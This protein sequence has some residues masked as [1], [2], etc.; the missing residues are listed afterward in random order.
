M[1]GSDL[2]ENLRARW[3]GESDFPETA[4]RPLTDWFNQKILKKVYAEHDRK[5]IETQL[6][7]DYKALRSDDE[8]K[9]GAI[10]DDLADDGIDGEELLDDFAKRSTMYRHLTQCLDAEK[11]KTSSDSNWEEDKIE[12]A[13]DTMQKNVS[14][15]L[16]S[17]ERKGELPNGTEAEIQ[18]P[19]ILSCPADE[20]STQ[21][22]FARA[23]N[24]GYICS[25]H[26]DVD[27]EIQ[28]DSTEQD[29]E[30]PEAE[31]DSQ[32]TANPP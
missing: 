31:S 26:S 15:V 16:R 3:V 32:T 20:C 18:T 21:T 12:Y 13:R 5:A 11:N 28:T 10:I 23:K 8:V 27:D 4:T 1:I 24:R 7:S 22:R 19:I 2:N 9:R 25:E 17:L 30:V 14:D 6:E 29:S